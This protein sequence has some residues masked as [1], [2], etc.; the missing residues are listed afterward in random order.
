MIGNSFLHKIMGFIW[1]EKMNICWCSN[2]LPI[3]QGKSYLQKVYILLIFVIFKF[4]RGVAFAKVEI[5]KFFFHCK[6]VIKIT[7]WK[8]LRLKRE[9]QNFNFKIL[10]STQMKRIRSNDFFGTKLKLN[11]KCGINIVE[12]INVSQT[13]DE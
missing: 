4:T 6:N 1:V 2:L 3:Y 8:C 12:T 7:S 13:I 5:F 9:W 10:F 11:L